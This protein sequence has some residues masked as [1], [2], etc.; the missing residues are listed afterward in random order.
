VTYSLQSIRSRWCI[1]FSIKHIKICCSCLNLWGV[2]SENYRHVHIT[3]QSA[4]TFFVQKRCRQKRDI[5][6]SI[7][8]CE[9]LQPSLPEIKCQPQLSKPAM[10]L[11]TILK[12]NNADMRTHWVTPPS[13]KNAYCYHLTVV[14]VPCTW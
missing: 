7:L 3:I 13:C 8:L 11:D 2:C 9:L 6:S 1:L 10:N 5:K 12:K 14:L 4:D